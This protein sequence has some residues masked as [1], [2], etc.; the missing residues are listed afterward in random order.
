MT[1]HGSKYRNKQEEKKEVVKQVAVVPRCSCGYR[2]RGA[3]H[4]NGRHHKG[5]G[6]KVK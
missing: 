1:L 3:N 5:S 4:E 6:G 2:M